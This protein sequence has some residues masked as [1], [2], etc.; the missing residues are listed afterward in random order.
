MWLSHKN[1]GAQAAN[2]PQLVPVAIDSIDVIS[3]PTSA[4]CCCYTNFNAIKISDAPTPVDINTDAIAAA[5]ISINRAI[6]IFTEEIAAFITSLN[7]CLVLI[8]AT[9]Q[10]YITAIGIAKRNTQTQFHTKSQYKTGL[11]F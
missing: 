11:I 1:I 10:A 5:A 6:C 7:L 8:I 4:K 9:T 3:A 2:V